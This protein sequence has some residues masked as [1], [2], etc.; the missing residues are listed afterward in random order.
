[1]AR[2]FFLILVFGAS[3]V[4]ADFSRLKGKQFTLK[5]LSNSSRWIYARSGRKYYSAELSSSGL[6]R[7][8]KPETVRIRDV[9]IYENQSTVMAANNSI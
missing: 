3:G 6:F 8:R 5:P 7:T 9:E 4:S 2:A 1:M